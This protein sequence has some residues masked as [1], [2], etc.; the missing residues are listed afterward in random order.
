[1]GALPSTEAD[2]TDVNTPAAQI[3]CEV[4]GTPG[5]ND[6]PGRII[7]A[8][9][10]DGAAVTI[11]R[12]RITSGGQVNIGG[13]LTQSGFTSQ[14]TR[15]SSESDI[16]CLKGNVHNSFI[17]FQDTDSTSDFT[18][19]SDDASG[20]VMK[21]PFVI[22]DR[23][24]NAYRFYLNSSGNLG[25]GAIPS[26]KLTVGGDINVASGSNIESTSSSGTLRIQG[27][28]TYP[29][30]NILLGGGNGTDDIRFRTTGASTTQTERMR[31]DSSGKVLIGTTTAQITPTDC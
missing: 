3:R 25:I 1:M 18:V 12:L 5:S 26:R 9:T 20:A 23:N 10:A 2:G 14:I 16:L 8:T 30:G 27:G 13:N 11:E 29:G 28:S 17:R 19:G 21:V 31:I 7:F 24:N 22:Y 4:D 6:M 15:N